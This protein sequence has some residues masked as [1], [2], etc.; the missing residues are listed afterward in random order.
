MRCHKRGM[1]VQKLITGQMCRLMKVWESYEESLV[2]NV[3]V[4]GRR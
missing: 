2:Q 3:V 4:R 1:V